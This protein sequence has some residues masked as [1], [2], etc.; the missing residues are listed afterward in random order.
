MIHVMS[1][2]RAIIP[3]FILLLLSSSNSLAVNYVA[4]SKI[5]PSFTETKDLKEVTNLPQTLSQDSLGICAAFAAGYILDATN[6]RTQKVQNPKTKQLEE[7]DCSKLNPQKAFSRIDLA[8]YS[9]EIPEKTQFRSYYNKIVEGGS[10]NAILENIFRKERETVSHECS[11][12]DKILKTFGDDKSLEEAQIGSW[13]NLKRTYDKLQGK[14][15]CTSCEL[16]LVS[17]ARSELSQ[18]FSINK[19]N[20]EILNAFAEDTYDKFLAKILIPDSCTKAD[21]MV[22]LNDTDKLSLKSFPPNELATTD[23]DNSIKT[24]KEV[25]NK[26]V[27]IAVNNVC[28]G[29]DFNE[30]AT[31]RKAELIHKQGSR[32]RSTTSLSTTQE[33]FACSK[34]HSVVISGYR[35]I[36]KDATKEDTCRETLKIQNS[37]GETWQ[38]EHND[39]WV[40]ARSFMDRTA[41]LGQNLTWIEDK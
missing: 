2:K 35:K 21:L 6:C 17:T 27:P 19:S 23:Y 32:I 20:T 11:S 41:Y 24:I 5:D 33:N 8:R 10:T 12:I 14:A 37:W 29:D 39:G 13:R 40:D 15:K 9:Q 28:L 34:P 30:K 31:Q 18:D 36:C 4:F 22:N 26:R 16:D 3:T 1:K 7:Q 38:K 25:L